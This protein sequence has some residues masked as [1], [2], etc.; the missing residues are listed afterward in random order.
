MILIFPNVRLCTV[1]HSANLNTFSTQQH[2]ISFHWQCKHKGPSEVLVHEKQS[3]I[4]KKWKRCPVVLPV[5]NGKAVNPW[6]RKTA[7]DNSALYKNNALAESHGMAEPML[8]VANPLS[9]FTLWPNHLL[10][11]G[12][13]FPTFAGQSEHR[14]LSDCHSHY[15]LA[16][17]QSEKIGHRSGSCWNYSVAFCAGGHWMAL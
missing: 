9:W 12:N 13:L 15:L 6:V 7:S 3:N 8:R 14:C 2:T 1:Y 16:E 10:L 11:A 4:P 17:V 5:C